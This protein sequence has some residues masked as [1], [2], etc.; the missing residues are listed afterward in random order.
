MIAGIRAQGTSLP[1]PTKGRTSTQIP[2]TARITIHIGIGAGSNSR[3]RVFTLM[4][5]CTAPLHSFIAPRCLPGN[6]PCPLRRAIGTDTGLSLHTYHGP[7]NPLSERILWASA[8][9]TYSTNLLAKP[10]WVAPTADAI[11]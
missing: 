1:I 6:R 8:D 3:R 7:E 5:P 4:A 10:W 9:I 2:T 11:G